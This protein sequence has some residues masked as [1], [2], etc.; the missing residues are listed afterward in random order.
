M[1][2]ALQGRAGTRIYFPGSPICTGQRM[3]FGTCDGPFVVVQD[4]GRVFPKVVSTQDSFTRILEKVSLTVGNGWKGW[5]P[6]TLRT[7]MLTNILW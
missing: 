3:T 5:G 6:P 7:R 4:L 1:A 2:A